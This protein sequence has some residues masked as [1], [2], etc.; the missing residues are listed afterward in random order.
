MPRVLNPDHY[1]WLASLGALLVGLSKGGLPAIG[2]LSVPILSLVMPPMKAAV[3][4]LP[5][6]VISDMAG[7]WLYR[8]HFSAIN[9]RIL[10]PAGIVGVLIGWGTVSLVSERAITFLIGLMGVL[11]CLQVWLRRGSAQVAK[12]AHRGWGSLWGVVSGFTSFISHA[13]A[14]PF[15]IYMLPQQLAKAQF[16]GTAT[17]FFAIINATKI[18]PYQFLQPYTLAGLREAAFLIPSALIGTVLGAY[19]TKRLSDK[20]F[21]LLVQIGLFGVSVKLMLNASGWMG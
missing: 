3:L 15:Q 9:L 12:P 10:V 8:R 17:L 6:F 19:L 11:F 16:A 14:P 2:M 5:I 4:L 1:F 18:V 21:Y 7:I 13:G 20:W